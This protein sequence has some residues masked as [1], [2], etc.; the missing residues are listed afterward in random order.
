MSR[1][2]LQGAEALFAQLSLQPVDQTSTARGF[3]GVTPPIA[4]S[5]S[6]EREKEVTA[7]LM[8]ELRRQNSFESE[9]EARRR[10]IVLQLRTVATSRGFSADAA[11][12]VSRG[13]FFEVFEPML[14]E[15]E[16][17]SDVSGV[18]DAYV[19]IIKAKISGI[20]VNL[21]IARLALSSI[22]DGMSR[23]DD[24]L[25][26][27]IDNRCVQS[28]GGARSTDEILRLVPNVQVFRDS[29]RCIILWAQRRAIYSNVHG[30][31]GDLAFAILVARICQLYPNAVAAA[32][33]S[34]FFILMYRWSWS[35]PVI[36]K[37]IEEG[38]PQIRMWNPKLYP[39]DRSH[40]M[41]IISP[42]YPAMC[43]THNVTASTQM[44]MTEEFKK[45]ADIVDKV[46][47]GKA[48]WSELF[49][50][51]GFFHK[52]R[53]YLQVVAST[54]NADLQMKWAG[55]VESRIRQLVMK[56]EYV[57]SLTLAHPFIQG[58]EQILYCL[59]DEEVRLVAQGEI[60][61]AVIKRKKEEIEG[62][63]D[64][65]VVYS[66]TFYI[67]LLIEPK[68]AGAVGPRRLD[69]SYPIQEFSK[70]VRGWEKFDE[71]MSLVVQHIKSSSLPDYVY[72][73]G[74]RP[75]KPEPKRAKDPTT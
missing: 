61:D 75:Q 21:P 74:E 8:D 56:L 45:A 62:K 47:V 9:E 33:V 67:G 31:L 3:L 48:A 11:T 16:D 73:I 39:A 35:Q 58:F 55:R 6:N 20:P 24:T 37:Q 60:S 29:L 28:L 70:L 34:R 59:T 64:G 71:S 38:P 5:E 66:T 50:K 14:M 40:R 51:D 36:L 72:D 32:I 19:P 12:H 22:P 53:Y 17:V 41:P 54:G 42:A 44:I 27:N 69:I 4:T 49:S 63:E 1:P 57:D 68:Q 13:D 26:R 2:V 10:K 23:R 65:G 18:P 43:S 15:L 46:I 52:Y 25:L 7:T 30:F